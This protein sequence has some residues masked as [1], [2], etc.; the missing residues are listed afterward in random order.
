MPYTHRERQKD[1]AST[2]EAGDA[3]QCLKVMGSNYVSILT[4]LRFFETSGTHDQT[5]KKFAK[6]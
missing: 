2:I 5:L 3:F 4:T 1:Q 6:G